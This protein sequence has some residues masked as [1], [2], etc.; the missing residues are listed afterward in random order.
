MEVKKLLI[1]GDIILYRAAFACQ[2]K[3]TIVSFPDGEGER[4]FDKMWVASQ[5]FRDNYLGYEFKEY[6]RQEPVLQDP[7]LMETIVHSIMMNITD[8]T[9][10]QDYE[11]YLTGKG[12]YRDKIAVTHGYKANR[13]DIDKPILYNEA[14]QHLIDMWC[15]TVVNEMEADDMLGIQQRN[16]TCICTIDKD[17]DM[18]PGWH[19]DFVKEDMYNVSPTEADF[20]FYRQVLTGD[21]TDNIK[22]LHGIGPVRA[23][24]ILDKADPDN[25]WPTI[26][27]AYQKQF[28]EQAYDRM[29]ENGKL[30]WI[31]RGEGE[32]WTGPS[33]EQCIKSASEN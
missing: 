12:N 17:L 21:D 23:L 28:G 22:G 26:Y 30:L 11:I 33:E 27:E 4:R 15:A 1:D 10:C 8:N 19:Y 6:V 32:Y 13:K 9:L 31:L 24:K 3:E 2:K 5:W 14:K 16:D 20:A 29:I 18:V 7:E 25:V